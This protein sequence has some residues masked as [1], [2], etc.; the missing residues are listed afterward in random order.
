M[1]EH[2]HDH[3]HDHEHDHEHS[4]EHGSAQEEFNRLVYLQNAYNQQYE[5]I[6]RELSNYGMA[7]AALQRNVE[8]L[9]RKD[10]MKGS[11]ILVNAEGGTYIE[12]NVKAIDKVMTYVGAGYLVEKKVDEAKSYLKKNIENEE[13]IMKRLA[14][15]GQ[16]IEGELMKIHYSL[17]M[18]QQ[19]Q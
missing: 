10:E 4:H 3:A 2:E 9:D 17:E 16:K 15:D 14:A 18:L 5:A 7:H 19:G 12:A 13:E 8:L 6:T 11:G 1:A